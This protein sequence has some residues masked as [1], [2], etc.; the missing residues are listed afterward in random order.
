MSP[1]TPSRWRRL[2]PSLVLFVFSVTLALVF[3]EIA[4]RL[5]APQPRSE[6]TAGLYTPDP[7]RRYR[8]RPGHVGTVANGTEFDTTV[9]IGEHGLRDEP[10]V[11]DRRPR[12]LV[13]GDSYVFGWGVERAD[14]LAHRLDEAL[15]DVEVLNAGTPG[16]GLP[17][18]V[19]WLEA[20]GLAFAP[21]RVVLAVFL[22]NDLLDATSA[23]R[24]V[25]IED[26]L[27]AESDRAG[28]L[29][30]GLWRHAHLVRLLKNALPP[31]LQLDLRRALGL[32]EPR[33]LT[34]LRDALG[35]YALEPTPLIAEG[36]ETTRRA[37]DRLMALA[38][39]TPFDVVMV[40]VPDPLQVDDRR[41]A[42]SLDQLVD[43]PDAYD[44]AVPNRFFTE[45]AST[46]GVPVLD[47]VPVFREA[48]QNAST[49]DAPLYFRHD[50]HWTAAGHAL[51]AERTSSLV[52]SLAPPPEEPAGAP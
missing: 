46:R 27:V 45:L 28:G 38:A 32:P 21:R 11:D 22:G 6:V 36:R 19:D 24:E 44:P 48:M 18:Q 5:V 31:A 13:L 20:H 2:L 9:T 43:E 17:D 33:T 25:V 40:F 10:L 23:Y 15:P 14:T 34:Y 8:L 50:P 4:V 30:A 29:R 1:A 12:W 47:L 16:F 52:R 51:A 39:E 7:P 26:G 37:M 49:D 35:G 41:W 3:A 42:F